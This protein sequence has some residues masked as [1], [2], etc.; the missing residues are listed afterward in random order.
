MRRRSGE[1]MRGSESGLRSGYIQQSESANPK[2]QQKERWRD[3]GN[4]HISSKKKSTA[5]HL[6]RGGESYQSIK[7]Q[8]GLALAT[9]TRIV[10]EAEVDA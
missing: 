7:E 6:L 2:N 8:T 3:C 9:I 5:L 4:S 10:K 1:E